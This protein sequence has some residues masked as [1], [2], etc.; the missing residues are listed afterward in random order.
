M[1]R[2]L[3]ALAVS[4]ALAAGLFAGVV[5]GEPATAA[6]QETT[7]DGTTVEVPMLIGEVLDGLV[8]DGTL[9]DTQA[10]AVAA[11]LAEI[12]PGRGLRCGPGH[13][14]RHVFAHIADILG[15]EPEALHDGLVDGAT[16]ADL[17]AAAGVTP[18]DVVAALL[19][20]AAGRLDAAVE[21]GRIDAADAETRLAELEERFTDLVNGEIDFTERPHRR[22]PM[23]R[24]GTNV[25]AGLDA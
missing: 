14:G 24:R 16:I 8:A 13:H 23:L 3:A 12:R 19:V 6:A 22:G 15:M 11:A 9:T 25:G 10:D 5:L 21:S 17:A 18:D 2:S 7:L 4:G 20:D 1:R